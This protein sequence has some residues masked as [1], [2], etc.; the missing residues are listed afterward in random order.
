MRIGR[1]FVECSLLVLH[2][3]SKV[4]LPQLQWI[5]YNAQA[6]LLLVE[7]DATNLVL[8]THHERGAQSQR[9]HVPL[10]LTCLLQDLCR[11]CIKH[12]ASCGKAWERLGSILEREQAYKVEH[13]S[14][15][16]VASSPRRH[17][18]KH[19][20]ESMLGAY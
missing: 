8:A 17:M 2:A 14:C 19:L 6:G 5:E 7:P 10:L 3:C 12:N 16:C 1:K 4:Q 18:V 11:K 13:C 20:A 9:N 15:K